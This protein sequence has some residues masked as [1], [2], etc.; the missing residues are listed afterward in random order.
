MC[1]CVCD[2][3]YRFSLLNIIGFLVKIWIYI[4]LIKKMFD[5]FYVF[6]YLNFICVF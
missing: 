6:I 2:V 3:G 1:L 4:Y 5:G